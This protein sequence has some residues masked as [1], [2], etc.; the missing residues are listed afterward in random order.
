[1]ESS[2]L[3]KVREVSKQ[4]FQLPTEEKKKCAREPNDI[5]GYGNDTI[6]SEKQRLDWTDRVFLKVH[7][8]DQRQFKFWPQSPNDFRY[9]RSYLPLSYHYYNK[10][11]KYKSIFRDK[12]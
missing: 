5:E 7:P 8:E 6:Y 12:K 1:M 3:D 11:M 9:T 10:I 2:F 4:F